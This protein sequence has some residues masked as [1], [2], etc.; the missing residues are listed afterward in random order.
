MKE[1]RGKLDCL[2]LPLTTERSLLV[3]RLKQQ[4]CTLEG[5]KG[6]QKTLFT[7]LSEA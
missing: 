5:N 6:L 3:Q 7:K 1:K 4:C 2:Q